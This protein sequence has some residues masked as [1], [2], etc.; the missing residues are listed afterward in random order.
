MTG[1]S[2]QAQISEV[3]S[4]LPAAQGRVAAAI[5][6]DPE[7]IAFGVVGDIARRAKTSSPTVIR[8]AQRLGF[9]G[10]AQLREAVRTEVLEQVRSAVGRIDET[11]DRPTLDRALNIERSNIERTF[12]QLDPA[13]VN[14]V[15]DVLADVART[16]FVLPSEQ[17]RGLGTRFADEL[18]MCRDNVVLVESGELRA[19][20]R[21]ASADDGDVL[22]TFD[23]QRHESWLVRVQRS[24]V[25]RGVVP[26]AITDQLPCSLD[27]TDGYALTFSAETANIFESQVGAMAIANVFVA[28]VVDRRRDAIAERVDVLEAVW[29]AAEQFDDSRWR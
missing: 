24:V 18:A 29:T 19:V 6:D 22:V 21:L 15:S 12:E 5:V 23:T 8:F 27:L 14:A 10:Y 9:E 28:E 3:A 13:V 2:L 16:I 25:R 11:D 1:R 20:T 7:L 26:I 4:Q 17:M